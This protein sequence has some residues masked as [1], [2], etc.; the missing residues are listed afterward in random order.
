[1]EAPH[2]SRV[3]INTFCL[4]AANTPHSCICL[5]LLHVPVFLASHLTSVLE[6]AESCELSRLRLTCSNIRLPFIHPSSEGCDYAQHNRHVQ[7]SLVMLNEKWE[8]E[9]VENVYIQHGI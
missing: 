5:L 4:T 2:K 8:M 3:H 6:C 1:M 9:N 7:Y